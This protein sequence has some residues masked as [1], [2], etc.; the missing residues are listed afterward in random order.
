MHGFPRHK[1]TTLNFYDLREKN[2]F[3]IDEM[4]CGLVYPPLLFGDVVV[5]RCFFCKCPYVGR[6][7]TFPPVS[8]FGVVARGTVSALLLCAGNTSSGETNMVD[9]SHRL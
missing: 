8:R 3:T 9:H 2:D 5:A 1:R 4:H 6:E 7:G